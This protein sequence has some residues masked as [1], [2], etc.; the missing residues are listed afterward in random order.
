ME[1]IVTNLHDQL[2]Q[3]YNT[4]DGMAWSFPPKQDHEELLKKFHS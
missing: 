1:A 3:P 2:F 4:T